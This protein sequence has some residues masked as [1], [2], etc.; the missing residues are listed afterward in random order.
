[1]IREQLWYTRTLPDGKSRTLGPFPTLREARKYVANSLTD[2][3]YAA[4][5]REA[6]T[7]TDAMSADGK[8]HTHSSGVTYS[9]TRNLGETP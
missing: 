8:T 6:S 1:M 2:N 4:S 5:K 9:I 3:G 7:F